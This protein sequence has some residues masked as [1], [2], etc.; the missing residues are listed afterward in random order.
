MAKPSQSKP[1][2]FKAEYARRIAR[3]LEKG[4]TRQQ[5][6]GHKAHEHI[7]RREREKS[8]NEGLTNDQVRSIRKWYSRFN[9]NQ[10]KPEPD[11]E[12]VI[13]FARE[14]GYPQF[15]E[16][17]KVWD[18]A[19][20]TYLREQSKGTYSSRGLSYLEMLTDMAGV[21]SHGDIEWLYYH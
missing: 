1:R 10:R 7:E 12:D 21:R 2:D 6:R 14:Q 11:I 20:R 13:D 18:A 3:A 19:R 17:R 15:G 9:P 5:A 4:K 8:Q 16:Y